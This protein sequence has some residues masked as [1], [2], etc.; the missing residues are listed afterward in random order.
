[1]GL[2]ISQLPNDVRPFVA[3]LGHEDGAV[4]RLLHRHVADVVQRQDELRVVPQ[5]EP[6]AILV[7]LHLKRCIE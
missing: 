5:E 6:P 7:V 4:A 1:M 2:N 3:K